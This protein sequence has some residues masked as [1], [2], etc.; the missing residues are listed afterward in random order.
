MRGR[1]Q[2]DLAC[3]LAASRE[4]VQRLSLHTHAGCGFG[5][6]HAAARMLRRLDLEIEGNPPPALDLSALELLRRRARR[7]RRACRAPEMGAGARQLPQ[8]RPPGRP[9]RSCACRARA[10]CAPVAGAA[11]GA[12][13][14]GMWK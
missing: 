8:Q 4:R 12:D 11:A 1:A 9:A 7:P 10:A 13:R 5:G 14:R 2:F 6:M 3:A